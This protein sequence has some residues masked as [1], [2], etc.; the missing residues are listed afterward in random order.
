MRRTHEQLEQGDED[1]L[2]D[3]ASAAEIGS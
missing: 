1:E 2:K 3:A